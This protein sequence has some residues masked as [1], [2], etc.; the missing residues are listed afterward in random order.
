MEEDEKDEEEEGDGS[1]VDAHSSG[2]REEC[3]LLTVVGQCGER[4]TVH[5]PYRSRDP[6]R[7]TVTINLVGCGRRH[8]HPLPHFLKRNPLSQANEGIRIITGSEYSNIFEYQH[9]RIVVFEYHD[10]FRIYSN[11]F[12][13][14]VEL[15]SG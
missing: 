2:D 5:R 7:R 3:L 13:Y 14:L 12:E 8:H 11:I 9:F 15:I 6:R 10:E 1:A 4:L